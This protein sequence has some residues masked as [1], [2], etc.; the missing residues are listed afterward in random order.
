MEDLIFL[1]TRNIKVVANFNMRALAYIIDLLIFFF[2]ILMPFSSI[3]Y[4][5]VGLNVETLEMDEI[6][7]NSEIF[8][9]LA[10]GYFSCLAIF[11][12]YL[13]SFEFILGGSVGKKMLQL[14]V[15]SKSKTLT[16]RQVILRNLTKTFLF[17]LLAFDCFLMI[18]DLQKRR[19]SDFLANTL[20]VSTRKITKKFGAVNEL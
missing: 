9:L 20:V 11:A 19:V 10:I 4:E 2:L 14:S 12:F 3:Y 5:V 13:I 16:L 18:F 1:P 6:M 15:V 7:N 17:N 8:A